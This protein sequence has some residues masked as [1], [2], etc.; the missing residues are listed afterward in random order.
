MPHFYSLYTLEKCIYF[1]GGNFFLKFQNNGLIFIYYVEK[2]MLETDHLPQERKMTHTVVYLLC[3]VT[4]LANII[5][6]AQFTESPNLSQCNRTSRQ[7]YRNVLGFNTLLKNS[8]YYLCSNYSWLKYIIYNFGV[9]ICIAIFMLLFVVFVTHHHLYGRLMIL[10]PA[11]VCS[12]QHSGVVISTVTS[13]KEGAEFDLLVRLC[14]C[15]AI[16]HMV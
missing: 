6:I 11:F 13:H 2:C 12:R 8:S 5:L 4:V 14:H 9:F 1:Q 3:Q 16:V 10:Q 7:K 15:Y